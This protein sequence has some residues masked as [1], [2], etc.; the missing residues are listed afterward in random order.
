MENFNSLDDS[1]P[2]N[3]F[4]TS[5]DTQSKFKFF[6]T[7]VYNRTEPKDIFDW[8]FQSNRGFN[9]TSPVALQINTSPINQLF[10]PTPTFLPQGNGPLYPIP[11]FSTRE[12][13]PLFPPTP[14]EINPVTQEVKVLNFKTIAP[15]SSQIRIPSSMDDVQQCIVDALSMI[16]PIDAKI[17][18]F[19]F[20]YS[21]IL[22]GVLYR[23]DN[24][25]WIMLNRANMK[26]YIVCHFVS[27]GIHLFESVRSKLNQPLR[28]TEK[29]WNRQGVPEILLLFES[30][31]DLKN[32]NA[33][34][35][36]QLPKEILKY[37]RNQ[38]SFQKAV[39]FLRGVGSGGM[40]LQR[41]IRKQALPYGFSPIIHGL[42][43][44]TRGW[45]VF[46]PSRSMSGKC[47]G[48]KRQTCCVDFVKA[49]EEES[50]EIL[51]DFE[52]AVLISTILPTRMDEP[53]NRALCLHYQPF[54]DNIRNEKYNH[55]YFPS[56]DFYQEK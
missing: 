47:F 39:E 42:T 17:T 4:S 56:A 53:K 46:N 32:N 7:P 1:E 43:E 45:K 13:G 15:K 26:L 35:I 10:Y 40:F 11:T 12:Y 20:N 38:H 2:F 5:E 34:R 27:D 48:G 49:L 36:N 14:Q 3:P 52:Q 8:S 9:N 51:E 37:N 54:I 33:F 28:Q 50:F 31:A 30:Y 29:I 24:L 19:G 6:M 41:Y 22:V 16:L 23:H 25:S 55:S 44:G 18:I 21:V